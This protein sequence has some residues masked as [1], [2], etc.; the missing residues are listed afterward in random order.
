MSQNNR[1]TTAT[2]KLR[3]QK[4]EENE[5]FGKTNLDYIT[6]SGLCYCYEE[7]G[8]AE[9]MGIAHPCG[10]PGHKRCLGKWLSK[11]DICPLCRCIVTEIS[12]I[13]RGIE[14]ITKFKESFNLSLKIF[15]DNEDDED[16]AEKVTPILS[17]QYT[18][19]RSITCN[20]VSFDDN[21]HHLSPPSIFFNSNIEGNLNGYIQGLTVLSSLPNTFENNVNLDISSNTEECIALY[22]NLFEYNGTSLG[23]FVLS[24]HYSEDKRTNPLD[25]N[26]DLDNSG[27]MSGKR[28]EL[29]KEALIKTISEIPKHG[30]FS[31][32]VFNDTAT[33]LTPLQ[34]VTPENKSFY[35]SQI[36]NIKANG[37]TN[38]NHGFSLISD[39]FDESGISENVNRVTVFVTDG[40]PSDIPDYSIIEKMIEKY[41]MMKLYFIT[42]C[43]GINASTVATKFLCNRHP[44]LSIYKH[45]ESLDDFVAFL[46]SIFSD[47]CN[48]FATNVKITFENVKPISSKAIKNDDGSWVINIPCIFESSA[49]QIAFECTSDCIPRIKIEYTINDCSVNLVAVEDTRRTLDKSSEWSI[50]RHII[51]KVNSIC[52][53]NSIEPSEKKKECEKILE[54]LIPGEYYQEIYDRINKRIEIITML[55]TRNYGRVNNNLNNSIL[56]E[57]LK[58]GSTQRSYSERISREVSER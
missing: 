7:F 53:D 10:H 56:E 38:Y 34:Q 15:G 14:P 26:F 20:E 23:T 40:Q 31:V 13:N 27:S 22:S 5:E 46:P 39:I 4:I 28:I 12:T 32:S 58:E 36:E 54:S 16:D 1:Q 44:N 41:P 50:M 43:D 51:L 35:L 47:V 18:N 57:N 19:M 33:Q 45:C 6:T 21:F 49:E 29:A 55:T 42:L 3:F 24:S 30:R 9:K 11:N 17:R 52:Y 8:S 48:V 25:C 37:N 2:A